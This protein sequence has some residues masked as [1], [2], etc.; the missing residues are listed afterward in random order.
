VLLELFGD[1]RLS[2]DIVLHPSMSGRR[3]RRSCPYPLNE[4]WRLQRVDLSFTSVISTSIC[5]GM[6]AETVLWERVCL[7]PETSRKYVPD[8]FDERT[9]SC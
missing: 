4:L 2:A 8:G 6:G 3:R 7:F 5:L 1:L 9:E